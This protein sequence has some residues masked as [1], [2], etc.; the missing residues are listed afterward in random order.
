[1]NKIDATKDTR[2]KTIER[3]VRE[4]DKVRNLTM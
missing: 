3:L 1:M 2:G 4:K